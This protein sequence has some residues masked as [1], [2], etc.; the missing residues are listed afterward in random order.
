[1]G[2]SGGRG[3][4]EPV[5]LVGGHVGIGGVRLHAG[6]LVAFRE[7]RVL[8]AVVVERRLGGSD[9]PLR[10]LGLGPRAAHRHAEGAELL[11]DGRHLRVGVVQLVQSALDGVGRLGHPGP[12]RGHREP[13]ALAPAGR[14]GDPVAGLVDGGLD[15]DEARGGGA[16]AA[17]PAGREHVAVAR[18]RGHPVANQPRDR[19]GTVDER[20]PLEES[21]DRRA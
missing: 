20:H 18:H 2:A 10:A 7:P 14:F 13:G 19:V 11:G 16:P 5:A 15:L 17:N 4:V 3:R 12:Q 6:G 1:M 9:G 21:V 8:G